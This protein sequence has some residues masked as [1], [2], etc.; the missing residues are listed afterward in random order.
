MGGI[1]PLRVCRAAGIPS[2]RLL[3]RYRADGFGFQMRGGELPL[4]QSEG[5]RPVHRGLHQMRKGRHDDM[6]DRVQPEGQ[7]LT[8]GDE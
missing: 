8:E 7:S 4:L 3:V 5:P 6:R 1:V 2:G